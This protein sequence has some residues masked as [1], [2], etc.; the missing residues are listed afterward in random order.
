MSLDV[1]PTN[2]GPRADGVAATAE[3]YLTFMLNGEEYGVD[4][5]RVQEIKG[6]ESA[7]DIPNTPAYIRGVINLRGTIVP[8]VDLRRRFDMANVEYTSTT[9]VIVLKVRADAVHERTMGF[10]V[11]AVSDVYNV[12]PEQLRSAPDFGIEVQVDYVKALAT[13]DDKMVILLDIDQLIGADAAFGDAAIVP[14]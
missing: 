3:Q 6:W 7:T 14:H 10:I 13:V 4:I 5:L 1:T 8:V 9:V 11:D 2:S 12:T